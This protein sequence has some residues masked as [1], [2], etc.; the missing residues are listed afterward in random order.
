MDTR[1][2]VGADTWRLGGCRDPRR[3]GAA[4]FDSGVGVDIAAALRQHQQSGR[5]AGPLVFCLQPAVNLLTDGADRPVGGVER[6]DE[7]RASPPRSTTDR[8]E[9][10]EQD[11]LP[12][13]VTSGKL[14]AHPDNLGPSHGV[15]RLS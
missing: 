4:A 14:A 6:V 7:L 1:V 5:G 11:R 13:V 10:F 2:R 12:A 8:G 3:P 9:V 15:P